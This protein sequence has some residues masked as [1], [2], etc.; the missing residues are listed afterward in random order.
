MR[1]QP[2]RLVSKGQYLKAVLMKGRLYATAIPVG[3][4]GLGILIAAVCF[5]VG[6]GVS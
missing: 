1:E 6:G 5:T 3:F 4:F 2:K